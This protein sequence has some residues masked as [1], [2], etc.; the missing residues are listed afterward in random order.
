MILALKI[1]IGLSLAILAG[2]VSPFRDKRETL[3]RL[4]WRLMGLPRCD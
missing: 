4:A 2:I 1:W 3:R